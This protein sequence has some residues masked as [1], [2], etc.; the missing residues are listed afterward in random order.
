M[1]PGWTTATRLAWSISR[2]AAMRVM[3][4][5]RAP[6]TPVAPPDRPVPAPRGTSATPWAAARRTIAATS[7]VEVG[8]ATASGIPGWR[9]SVSSKR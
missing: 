5:V 3:T 7:A 6:S 4:T 1:T 2:M 8:K 9:Y